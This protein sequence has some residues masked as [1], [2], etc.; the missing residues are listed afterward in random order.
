MSQS[1]KQE[2]AYLQR[3]KFIAEVKG[4][5]AEAKADPRRYEAKC[6]H[7]VGLGYAYVAF[8]VLV[9]VG[10][11][12]GVI[13]VMASARRGFGIE[14][15]LILILGIGLFAIIRALF[16]RLPD[17]KDG[18]EVTAK[19]APRLW[20]EV[21]RLCADL[22]APKIHVI[23]ITFDWNAS[24]SQIPAFGLFGPCKNVLRY[25]L[26]LMSA[27]S[28]DETRATIA[29]ELGH[30]AG[31]HSRFAGKAYRVV[32]IWEMAGSH[33][34]GVLA[35][36]LV[37]PFL[38]WYLPK[39]W[40]TTFPLR[41]LDEYVADAAATRIAGA[42]ANAKGLV[43]MVGQG[44]QASRALS[45][46]YDLVEVQPAPPADPVARVRHAL[47]EP[48]PAEE[49]AAA[50]REAMSEETGYDD[51]HPCLRE[52]IE[53]LP[54]YESITE[55]Q[56]IETFYTQVGTPPKPSAA[57]AFL[58]GKLTAELERGISLMWVRHVEPRW[59]AR[60]RA[61]ADDAK[62]LRSLDLSNVAELAPAELS[63]TLAKSLALRGPQRSEPL[64][65]A[66]LQKDPN[67]PDANM[68]LGM[69]LGKAGDEAAL[70]HLDLAAKD[71]KLREAAY[72]ERSRLA[73]RLGRRE[74][75]ARYYDLGA[76]EE[77]LNDRLGEEAYRFEGCRNLRAM[78]VEP[79]VLQSW[80]EVL[81]RATVLK[82]AYAIEFDSDVRSGHVH[83]LI[84]AVPAYGLM[85]A[86]E[87]KAA[88][89][90]TEELA[91]IDFRIRTLLHSEGGLRK[92]VEKIP[93][94]KIWGP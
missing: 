66:V 90:L 56:L 93:N 65:R 41:R 25:G 27:E 67:H 31:G 59:A 49:F 17:Q 57:D 37:G 53:A 3:E 73:E 2:S 92:T 12:V 82:A 8:V 61:V 45:D 79:A 38:K 81:N 7:I 1:G 84:V 44:K 86:D 71:P 21:D 78:A 48:I 40:A 20:E 63:Q 51:T 80:T 70:A 13:A 9:I 4:F 36:T 35:N 47:S 69:L 54:G 88:I 68:V 42:E 29:H 77:S 39:L 30:F 50:I 26:P 60:H 32:A 16:Q 22:K 24:A 89:Q 76:E 10:L 83:Q 14:V 19:Q 43:R 34:H 55:D 94:A 18:V 85:V 74:E 62:S 28:P 11:I 46:L 23:R 5:E 75:A 15:K 91:D 58:G 87:S 72:F 64:A 52:R 6:R 33:L